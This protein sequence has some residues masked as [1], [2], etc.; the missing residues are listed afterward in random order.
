MESD[1]RKPT[2]AGEVDDLEPRIDLPAP[3]AKMLLPVVIGVVIVF[4]LLTVVI[5]R[6]GV[7]DK[8]TSASDAQIVAAMLTLLG[9]L[10]A[11][12]FTLT[13][14]L[15]KHSIDAHTAKLAQE[16]ERSRRSEAREIETR[17]RL[18]TSIKA[19]ELLTTPDGKPAPAGRQAGALFVLGS[20][21]LEQLDLALA[22]L[23]ENWTSSASLSPSAAIWVIDRALRSG[24]DDL[25]LNAALILRANHRLLLRPDGFEWPACAD[26]KWPTDAGYYA[27]SHLVAACADVLVARSP[28]KLDAEPTPDQWSP[29][30]TNYFIV[31][32]D[33]IRAHET[34][35]ELQCFAVAVLD[36][37]V[38]WALWQD[39]DYSLLLP[40]ASLNLK[41]TRAALT[42][43]V[44]RDAHASFPDGARLVVE[45]LR[46]LYSTDAS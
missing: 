34:A 17:L 30:M 14:V 21:P 2:A 25:D 7:F 29:G 38:E 42:P 20:P 19:V 9:G 12:A 33:M 39:P 28:A 11:S 35:T 41:H 26:L 6:T 13:G 10:V 8:D 31:Q 4:A 23:R 3:A 45:K 18:E 43:D 5:W 44:V 32:F 16:T 37:L 1:G 22:L 24:D 15:L 46:A 40:E 36:V 27:R